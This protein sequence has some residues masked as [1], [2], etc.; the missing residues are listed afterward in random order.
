MMTD[1][2]LCPG[3]FGYDVRKLWI[4]FKSS[5]LAGG[6]QVQVWHMGPGLL[7]WAVGGSNDIQFLESCNAILVCFIFMLHGGHS[8]TLGGIPNFIS[9]LKHLYMY[10]PASFMCELVRGLPSVFLEF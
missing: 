8:K 10:I 2:C 1:F 7:L 4:L 9:V 5:I 3:H 6:H